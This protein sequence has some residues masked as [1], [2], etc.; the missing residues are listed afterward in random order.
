MLLVLRRKN[1]KWINVNKIVVWLHNT[2]HR[3]K[4]GILTLRGDNATRLILMYG[5]EYLEAKSDMKE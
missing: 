5:L 4:I 1:D 3:N 2:L